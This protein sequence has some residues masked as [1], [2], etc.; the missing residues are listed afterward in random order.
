MAQA[1][2]TS[3]RGSGARGCV[4]V[5]QRH[6]RV[7]PEAP[8]EFPHRL[9]L[10]DGL[11]RVEPATIGAVPLAAGCAATTAPGGRYRRSCHSN[12]CE[13]R[14]QPDASDEEPLRRRD[15]GRVWEDNLSEGPL[16]KAELIGERAF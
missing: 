11:P 13:R 6:A 16:R 1:S 8:N 2:G 14:P 4:E 9:A 10:F 12:K 5:A 15:L 3:S 7:L